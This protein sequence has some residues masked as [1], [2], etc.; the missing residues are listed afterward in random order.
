MWGR[1]GFKGF[2]YGFWCHNELFC[3]RESSDP[4][5]L[6]PCHVL[7]SCV[8][9]SVSASLPDSVMYTIHVLHGM[10]DVCVDVIRCDGVV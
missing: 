2:G 9:V 10:F 8:S 5:R 3:H 7:C 6:V 4:R 1:R